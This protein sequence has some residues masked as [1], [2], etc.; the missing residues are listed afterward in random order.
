MVIS[1][2]YFFFSNTYPSDGHNSL[3]MLPSLPTFGGM[4]S[5]GVGLHPRI[6]PST[7]YYHL[8]CPF[9]LFK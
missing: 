3:D 7:R 4:E 5:R 2:Y 1:N 6:H 9:E 8:A